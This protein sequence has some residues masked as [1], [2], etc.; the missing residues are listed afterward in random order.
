MAF[1][2]RK[3]IYEAYEEI[4][5]KIIDSKPYKNYAEAEIDSIVKNLLSNF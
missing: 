3:P 5:K 2:E 1:P 4:I